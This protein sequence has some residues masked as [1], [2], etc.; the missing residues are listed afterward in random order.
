MSYADLGTMPIS[1]AIAQ[2]NS[3]TELRKV[4]IVA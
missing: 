2:V 1:S 4:G 3:G